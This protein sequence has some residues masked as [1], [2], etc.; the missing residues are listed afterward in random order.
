M[1]AT[2]LSHNSSFSFLWK[3]RVRFCLWILFH[4]VEFQRLPRRSAEAEMSLWSVLWLL[5]SCFHLL[6]LSHWFPLLFSL[7]L[8]VFGDCQALF[9]RLSGPVLTDL[10][11]SGLSLSTGQSS[12]PFENWSWSGGSV[13]AVSGQNNQPERCWPGTPEYNSPENQCE[14]KSCYINEIF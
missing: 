9:V 3:E 6:C 5:L 1:T 14:V 4:F 7:M 8:S 13:S 12:S 11:L 10:W 2:T